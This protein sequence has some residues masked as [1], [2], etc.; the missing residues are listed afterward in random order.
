MRPHPVIGRRIAILAIA[1][2]LVGVL[3]PRAGP[4]ATAVGSGD[5]TPPALTSALEWT[6]P[7][8][9]VHDVLLIWDDLLNESLPLDRSDF[10]VKLDTGS[11]EIDRVEYTHAGFIDPTSAVT[12]MTVFL[13][14]PVTELGSLTVSY[15]PS[16]A[17][18]VKDIAGNV[19]VSTTSDLTVEI[20]TTGTFGAVLAL[21]DGNFGP[22]HVGLVF[23]DAVAPGSLPPASAFRVFRNGTEMTPLSPP[24]IFPEFSGRVLDI[25][26]PTGVRSGDAVTI[27]YTAPPSGGIQNAVGIAAPD[28]P[29]SDVIL[30]L[31]AQDSVGGATSSGSPSVTTDVGD[32]GP[33]AQDPVATNVTPPGAATVY[34]DEGKVDYPPSVTEYTFIGETVEIVVAPPGTA[35]LPIAIDFAIDASILAEWGVTEANVQL[36]RNSVPVEA[37]TGVSG[38]AVPIDPCIEA[39]TAVPA[40]PAPLE[41]AILRVLTSQASLWTFAVRFPWV[42]F[43]QPVDNEPTVNLAK[44]GQAIPVKFTIGGDHGLSIFRPDYPASESIDCISGVADA[45]EETTTAGSSSLSYAPGNG[46]YTYVWKTSKSWSSA[47]GGP[48]RRLILGFTDGSTREALFRFK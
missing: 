32:P 42:G 39:R 46:V 22:D 33:T 17:S 41:Y 21:V 23:N 48:C 9:P 24:T 2:A 12:I 10:E 25:G 14:E 26:L 37:C 28:F 38:T 43:E 1:L 20:F 44:A 5:V 18:P 11:R 45:I 30:L 16:V 31:I 40:A 19:V 4:V 15:T 47:P 29:D 27:R 35:E 13:T 8:T 36:L 3:A 34:I 6:G 7:N